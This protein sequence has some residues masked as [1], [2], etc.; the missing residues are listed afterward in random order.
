MIEEID[1]KWNLVNFFYQNFLNR[2]YTWLRHIYG[3]VKTRFKLHETRSVCTT[4]LTNKTV[5]RFMS[6]QW[7][8]VS[9]CIYINITYNYTSFMF[10]SMQI[11]STICTQKI[12]VVH[13]LLWF[14]FFD[15]IEL[16]C[17]LPSSSSSSLSSTLALLIKKTNKPE[18]K[19]Q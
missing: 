3:S 9:L 16:L 4:P 12:Y 7:I 14:F 10:C 5:Y 8:F 11:Y 6:D 18:R 1:L 19:T 15:S 2:V 17:A 13:N